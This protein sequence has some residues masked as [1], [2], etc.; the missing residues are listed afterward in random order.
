MADGDTYIDLGIKLRVASGKPE[1]ENQAGYGALT[2]KQVKGVLSLPQRG[3][4]VTDVS[5]PTLEDGRV[6]HFNGAKD[7]GVIDVPIKSIEADAGQAALSAGAGSNTTYSFQEVDPDGEAHFFYGRIQDFVRR[8]ATPSS[9]KGYI[10]KIAINSA[11][12]TGT[13]ET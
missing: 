4:T 10:A 6:E 7:G 9:F 13:E 11:R 3:D 5:E 1:T 12:F 8:E 2:W